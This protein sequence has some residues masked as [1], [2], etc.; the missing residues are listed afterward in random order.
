[1]SKNVERSGSNYQHLWFCWALAHTYIYI[2]IKYIHTYIY[3]YIRI[4]IYLWTYQRFDK[5][6]TR[7]DFQ[8]AVGNYA[9]IIVV[10]IF[11]NYDG[12]PWRAKESLRISQPH[13]AD[14]NG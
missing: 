9:C 12:D 1:M 13:D 3:R 10:S 6:I 4:F 8:G 7:R 5:F 11:P 2:R 14:P